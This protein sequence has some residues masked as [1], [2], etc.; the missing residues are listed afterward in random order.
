M[1]RYL[2]GTA[3]GAAAALAFA[4]I[5]VAGHKPGHPTPAGQQNAATQGVRCVLNTQMRAALE[6]PVL[7]TAKGNAQLKVWKNGKLSYN[8]FIL[9]KDRETF[10]A[11]HIHL[12][13][14][15]AIVQ[16]LFTGPNTT[17]RQ[18]RVKRTIDIAPELATALCTTPA[19]YYVNFHTL[20]DP[21]GAV[22]GNFRG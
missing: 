21:V 13:A 6:P 3:V 15:G 2:L 7:S 19:A 11:G 8:V 4:A 12:T 1:R 9:N 16:D 18:I 20:A 5:A 17:A 10:F 14:T 22:R